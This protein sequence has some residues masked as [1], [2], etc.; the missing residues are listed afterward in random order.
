MDNE[1]SDKIKKFHELDAERLAT[2]DKKGNRVYLYPEDVT[3]FWKNRRHIFYWFLIIIYLVLPWIYIK[4]K[5]FL[6]LDIAKME[7]TVAGNTFHGVEPILIF[8]TLITGLFFIAFLTS[9]FGRVWCGWGCP[10]TVFIQTIFSKI[11][12]LVEGKARQRRE[13]DR[14]PMSFNK[15]GRKIIKWILF[16]IV[17]LHITHTFIGYFVGP[18]ELFYMTMQNPANNFEI[19]MAVMIG[20]AI[21]LFDFGWFQEQFCII[22]CPYGRIQSVMMDENSLVVAYDEKRGEPRRAPAIKKEDEGDCINCYACVKVCPTG[23]D[24]RRGTQMECI[25]CTNCIDACDEIMTKIDRPKGLIRYSSENELKGKTHTFFT[26]RSL[27]YGIVSIAFVAIFFT[28]LYRSTSLSFQI[29]RGTEN[30]FQ[31]VTNTDGTKTVIN[32]FTLKISHQGEKQYQ[33][34]FQIRDPE[35]RKKITIVTPMVPFKVK[36]AEAKTPIFFRFDPSILSNGRRV[37][38]VEMIDQEHNHDELI[39]VM[40]APLVGPAN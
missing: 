5:P 12:T 33:L 6:M 31:V 11:E 39:S 18:R 2:T 20:T 35:L 16:T 10:Q 19:F 9:I 13:I 25:A 36:V 7:F 40:E 17:S 22:A 14:A 29:Y 1:K 30:P 21:I 23:I 34:L 37:I 38:E 3:G 27:L 4:G 26:L 24:I 8:L 32:H 28:F 15:L